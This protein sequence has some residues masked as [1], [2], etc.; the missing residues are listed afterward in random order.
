MSYLK[1][2]HAN[3]EDNVLFK[4]YCTRAARFIFQHVKT[5]ETLKRLRNAGT[6]CFKVLFQ[7]HFMCERLK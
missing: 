2:F 7:F 5:I 3:T 4:V 1:L 6:A